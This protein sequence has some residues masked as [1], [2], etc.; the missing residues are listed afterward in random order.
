MA[1]GIVLI[2]VAG[3]R[4]VCTA[5]RIDAHEPQNSNGVR[6]ELIVTT[7]LVLLVAAYCLSILIG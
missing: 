5:R 3:W 7:V 1:L 4:F 6:I 2:V